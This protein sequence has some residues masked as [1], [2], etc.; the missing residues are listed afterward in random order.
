M[1]ERQIL[2]LLKTGQVL[3]RYPLKVHFQEGAG[4]FGVSVPKRHFKRAVKRNLLKRRVREAFRLNA[5]RLGGR[6]Y[7]IFIYYI[8]KQV[9]E[10]ERIDKSLAQ[11][12]D[13]LAAR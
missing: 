3:F 5:A 12:L 4:E 2:S 1:N 9:E 6:S 11:V 10:Y 8:G 7:D 13:D